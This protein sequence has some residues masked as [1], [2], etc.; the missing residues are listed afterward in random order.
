MAT[1][2][3][4]TENEMK[5]K[6]TMSSLRNAK[7]PDDPASKPWWDKDGYHRNKAG[8]RKTKLNRETKQVAK[9]VMDSLFVKIKK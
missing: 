1:G 5:R 3:A 8:L 2:S 9:S 7:A 4:P 6:Q